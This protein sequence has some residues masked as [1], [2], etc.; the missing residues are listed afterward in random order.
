MTTMDLED[1]FNIYSE[2]NIYQLA[3]VHAFLA[4]F[5]YTA[6]LLSIILFF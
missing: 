1:S 5:L 2:M 6:G 4:F 3:R